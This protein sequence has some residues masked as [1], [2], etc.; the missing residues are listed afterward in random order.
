MARREF[1]FGGNL[2]GVV[3][4][5]IGGG[6][7]SRAGQQLFSAHFGVQRNAMCR[8]LTA[9]TAWSGELWSQFSSQGCRAA[10]RARSYGS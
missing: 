7:L 4:D 3:A 10:G 2:D 9:V 8:E 6:S 5:F 1:V